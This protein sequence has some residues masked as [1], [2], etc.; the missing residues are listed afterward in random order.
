MHRMRR[1]LKLSQ[2]FD[3]RT[4]YI[5]FN[6]QI[7]FSLTLSHSIDDIEFLLNTNENKI[8]FLAYHQLN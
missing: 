1:V 7:P 2:Y 4:L 6:F 5:K 8:L 3:L